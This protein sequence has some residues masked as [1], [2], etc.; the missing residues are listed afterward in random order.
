MKMNKLISGGLLI[1]ALALICKHL[2]TLP[3]SI[4]GFMMGLGISLEVVG[5]IKARFNIE[6]CALKRSIFKPNTK[7]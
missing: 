6:P 2:F 4:Y 7:N 3:D 5:I 1:T